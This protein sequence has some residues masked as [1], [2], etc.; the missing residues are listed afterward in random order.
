MTTETMTRGYEDRERMQRDVERLSGEG[1][2]V[3]RITSL[4][5]DACEVEYRLRSDALPERELVGAA[6][7]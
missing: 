5:D 4:A 1:W 7:E 6:R 3:E 2:I